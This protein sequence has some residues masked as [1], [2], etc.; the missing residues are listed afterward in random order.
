MKLF[1]LLLAGGALALGAY[2]V[3]K[4]SESEMVQD[5][6]CDFDDGFTKDMFDATVAR[7]AAV[8]SGIR[9]NRISGAKVY[10]R[11]SY[12]DDSEEVVIDFNDYGHI[13]GNYTISGSAS[14]DYEFTLF[15]E[16]IKR[17]V[18]AAFS[19]DDYDFSDEEDTEK[20]NFTK[21]EKVC[22]ACGRTVKFKNAAF[23]MYCG[24]KL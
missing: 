11:K 23:C 4:F 9:V 20:V 19:S 13:T 14:D 24:E 6:E 18:M 17:E 10:C 3:K 7:S 22:A 16:D 1:G 2:A 8:Y 12:S 15:A 21:G 5:K